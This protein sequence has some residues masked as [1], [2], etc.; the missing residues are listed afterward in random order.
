M[1]GIP[2]NVVCMRMWSAFAHPS[3]HASEEAVARA[4]G[5]LRTRRNAH[6][7]LYE[8]GRRHAAVVVYLFYA[9]YP[10]SLS[11]TA[12]KE[13]RHTYRDN[14]DHHEARERGPHDLGG[15][16]AGHGIRA[17]RALGLAAELARWPSHG[18]ERH[19]GAHPAGCCGRRGR[20][21]PAPGAH[22]AG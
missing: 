21:A 15:H 12:G 16:H 14:H 10:E 2:E 1:A 3:L 8:Y 5:L 9:L 20:T 13:H 11:T 22:G 18:C 19:A 7:L 6:V 4:L 17:R